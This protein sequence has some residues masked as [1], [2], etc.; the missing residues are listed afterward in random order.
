MVHP[1]WPYAATPLALAAWAPRPR[2]FPR[3]FRRALSPGAT[4]GGEAGLRPQFC[5]FGEC[6]RPAEA[7][8]GPGPILGPRFPDPG[9]RAVQVPRT[10]SHEPL[11]LPTPHLSLPS[12]PPPTGVRTILSL[13]C[14]PVR[15]HCLG[16][17]ASWPHRL[18][19]T[20]PCT[21]PALPRPPMLPPQHLHGSLAKAALCCDPQ[22]PLW[23]PQ[24][25]EPLSHPGTDRHGC[26]GGTHTPGCWIP[27]LGQFTPWGCR[28]PAHSH[29]PRSHLQAHFR[30]GSHS[31]SPLHS[32][33]TPKLCLQPCLDRT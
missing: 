2:P 23:A 24:T 4:L 30:P 8:G 28:Q 20:L 13:P 25:A 10:P 17:L 18:L 22:D 11:C 26:A 29:R 19:C 5:A 31:S 33:L 15:P 12:D 7:R 32:T 9:L 16:R 27:H 6:G 14:S 21:W 1:C 3:G